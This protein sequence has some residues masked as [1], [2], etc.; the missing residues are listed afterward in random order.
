MAEPMRKITD[1]EMLQ[2][3]CRSAR[4][5]FLVGLMLLLGGGFLA[6]LAWGNKTSERITA[7]ETTTKA[8]QMDIRA[9]FSAILSRL[10]EKRPDG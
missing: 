4:Q 7:A 5:K 9:G 1:C 6:A 2:R 10:E 8:I 3:A